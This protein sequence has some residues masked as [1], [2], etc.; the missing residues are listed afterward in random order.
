MTGQG[1]Y[2]RPQIDAVEQQAMKTTSG[3]SRASLKL[4]DGYVQ[5]LQA[6]VRT[7]GT[8]GSTSCIYSSSTS[9]YPMYTPWF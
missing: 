4:S 6:C 2:R 8:N 9:I 7:S 5:R 3:G 1:V